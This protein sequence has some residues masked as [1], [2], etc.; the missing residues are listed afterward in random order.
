M[1][2]CSVVKYV[3]TAALRDRLIMALALLLVVGASLS[4]FLGS[5]AISEP[6]Q[7]AVVFAAG[8]LRLAGAMGLILFIVFY[9]RRSFE[10]RDV[11]FLLSRPIS[12]TSFLI[13]HSVA[14]AILAMIVAFCVFVTVCAISPHNIESGHWLWAFSILAEYIM[15]ANVSLFFAMVLPNAAAGTLAVFGLYLLARMMGQILGIIESGIPGASLHILG[16]IMHGISLIIPRF[17]LMGQTS[18]LVYGEGDITYTFI[19]IQ[20]IAFSA[21][22]LLAAL[23]DLTRKQF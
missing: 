3:L 17:D 19:L 14:F 10:S 7:F 9:L 1:F 11:D 8:G 5:A 6:D 4:I 21:L 12:R 2:S 18:W 16:T 13:S 23:T 22:A 15:I 20:G